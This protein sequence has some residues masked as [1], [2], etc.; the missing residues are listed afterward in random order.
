MSQVTI[1]MPEVFYG[2]V[3]LSEILK[4]QLFLFH[5]ILGCPQYQITLFVYDDDVKNFGWCMALKNSF[6]M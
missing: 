6:F 3:I 2:S 1:W 4:K 5:I